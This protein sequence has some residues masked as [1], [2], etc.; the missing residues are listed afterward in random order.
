MI[1][2]AR[3]SFRLLLLNEIRL[4]LRGG[5]A[6]GASL[7][8]LIISQVLL[9]L[10]ALSMV[11]ASTS[12]QMPVVP[13]SG[14]IMLTGGLMAM[15][16]MMTS[17]GLAGAVQSLYTRGD[18]DLLL[19]SPVDRRSVIG[20]R[21]SAIAL[22]VAMEI[23]LLV[24]P[25]A[26]VFV[27]FGRFA[28]LKAYLLVPAMAMLATSIGLS[29]TLL[30]FRTIGPRRTRIVVQILA[31]LVGMGIMLS[32][33]LPRMLG[34]GPARGPGQVSMTASVDMLLRNSGSFRGLMVTPAHWVMQ[35]YLPTMVFLVAAAGLLVLTIQLAG[36]SLVNA[37]TAITAG[38][39][40]KPGRVSTSTPQFNRGFRTV[41]VFKELKI[42][43]R[44]PFLIAQILQQS[45]VALPAA[46][47]LWRFHAGEMPMPW[48][49]LIVLAAG[50]AGPLAWL[51]I[52]A[53]DAPDLLASAPVTRAALI[54]AKI[55]AAL[56]PVLP[57]CALPLLFLM[58][59]HPWFAFCASFSAAAAALTAA[60][61]NMGNPVTKRRDSFKQRHRGNAG[62]GFLEL[63]SL[64]FW[65]FFAVGL[66]WAGKLL[67][68]WR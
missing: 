22:T 25:F 61:I 55:E 30:S 37:L 48:L 67:A 10:F 51:T 35:G 8:L 32:I 46:V 21:M 39:G 44:D 31:V 33:Y 18:F 62:R 54:R 34:S 49:A 3:S 63:V 19:S 14:L 45:L 57:L 13:D 68:G 29:L 15:F 53:E 27:L 38:G 40:S 56:L 1:P 12:L 4:Y 41:I 64:I 6:K 65:V 42:I 2:T 26:N 23:A 7:V 43:L 47:V 52:T 59:T 36:N 20:V 58:R 66:A 17:R 60:L 5:M 28:W 9:H 50:I 16:M 24:W 11:W